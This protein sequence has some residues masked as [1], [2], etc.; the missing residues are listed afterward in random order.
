MAAGVVGLPGASVVEVK[1]P[2]VESV[3]T[4][5]PVGVESPALGS[6]QTPSPVRMKKWSIYGEGKRESDKQK[7]KKTSN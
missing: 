3:T 6:T 7:I 1:G 4:P 5:V 2:E